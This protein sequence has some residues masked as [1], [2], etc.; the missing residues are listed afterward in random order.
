MKKSRTERP[1]L[2]IVHWDGMDSGNSGMGSGTAWDV[3]NQSL[4]SLGT[5]GW[6]G[7]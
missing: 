5:L 2:P 4:P 7:Q 1:F 6:E 3:P